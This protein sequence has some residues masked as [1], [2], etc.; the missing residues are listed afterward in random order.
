MENRCITKKKLITGIKE[1]LHG[2]LSVPGDKSIS[3]RGLIIGAIS[4]GITNLYNFLP[5]KD[6][7]STL[8]ALKALGVEIYRERTKVRIYGVGIKGLSS[9]KKE[10]NMG[11]SGTSTRLMAGLLA[12][13]KFDSVITGDCSLNKRPM[14]RI[15]YPLKR[16][17]AKI[18]LNNEYLPMK[19][20]G[21]KLKACNYQMPIASAQV[22]S[23]LI[24][25]ALQTNSVTHIREMIPTRN[26]T[27]K[28]VKKFGGDVST[29]SDGLTITIYPK[30][31][32]TGKDVFIPGDFS[33]AAYFIT[34]AL[35]IPNSKVVV[36]HVGL[37]PTR[38]G[39]LEVIKNMGG[40]IIIKQTS[41]E[42]EEFGDIVAE[43]SKLK[44]IDL[45]EKDIPG[46]IDELPMV[47]LLASSAYGISRI[48]GAEE[49][50]YK[51]TDRIYTIV[52][53]LTK[54]GINIHELNDGFS[55]DGRKKWNVINPDLNSHGDHRIGMMLTIAALKVNESVTLEQPEAI[56]ISYPQFF[57]DVNKLLPKTN[58][59]SYK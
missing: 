49:L 36:H 33:S 44:P 25:A 29:S 24:L 39:L 43:T 4:S 53:E 9:P 28:M 12:G 14:K 22:K 26:H 1:G 20:V 17:G 59:L 42:D 30:P 57:S 54:L 18:T 47:A 23:A 45:K 58:K 32:L 37:N 51:E 55:I 56:N 41:E 21:T 11:N 38:I 48:T 19:I 7:L 35:I 27:E 50:R 34:A 5:A 2:E 8:N 6:C 3:H 40:H 13:Q 16:M 10:L 46:I 15:Q 52:H 31:N